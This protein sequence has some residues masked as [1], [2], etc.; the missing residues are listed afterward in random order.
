MRKASTSHSRERGM[1]LIMVLGVLAVT[2]LMVVH[3]M[4]VCEVISKEAYVTC[5]RSQLRYV[6]E[7]AADHAL[8]MHITDRR[9][10]SDR[11]LGKSDETRVNET[12]FEPWM[13]DRREHQLYGSNTYAYI[14]GVEKSIRLD[15]TDTFKKNVDMDDTDT[16]EMIDNF[17]D[18]LADYTDADTNVR[19][20]GKEEGDY[21]GDG[22]YA[23]PRDGSMQFKE[24]VYWLDGWDKVITGEVTIIPPNKKTLK[25]TE[26]G[27]VSF[28]AVSAAEI[29]AD[30]GSTDEKLTDEELQEI[31]EAR[32]R[33]TEESVPLD[34]SLS[35]DMFYNLKSKYS[36]T[37][38]N[39][40]Q[41]FASAA[42]DDGEVR[43]IYSV[44][45]EVDLNNS[46]IFAERESQSLSIWNRMIQ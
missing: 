39:V 29:Q 27:K 26:N 18:V 20:N 36:F 10:Y 17:C 46:T 31:L 3:M 40:A 14:A 13:A 43:V 6:A 15:K 11:E 8:W 38:G 4:T 7:A 5:R 16:L 22:L 42:S 12:D 44:I 23:M 1:A 25:E 32:R 34:E 28:F 19:L 41:I 9:L 2:L 24:E 30:M 33:W 45:R 21:E 37:E 35:S